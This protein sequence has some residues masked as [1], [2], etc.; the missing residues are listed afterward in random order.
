MPRRP[1]ITIDDEESISSHREAY[2][3]L[4]SIYKW[5]SPYTVQEDY[6]TI[7]QQKQY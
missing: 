2:D 5:M 1:K 4:V 7:L 3:I 6:I